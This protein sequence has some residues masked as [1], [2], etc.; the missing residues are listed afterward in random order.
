MAEAPSDY[1]LRDVCLRD[2]NTSIPAFGLYIDMA[3]SREF[4]KPGILGQKHSTINNLFVAGAVTLCAV[5][6]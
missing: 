2:L 3:H 5:L 4:V 1:Q 6:A